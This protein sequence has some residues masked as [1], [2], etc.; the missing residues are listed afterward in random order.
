MKTTLAWLKSHLDTEASLDRIV[1]TLVMSGLEVDSIE[2]RAK[3][4]GAFT[5]ARVISAEP[6]PNADKLRVCL[7]D[8]GTEQ[9]RVVCGAPNARRGMLGVFAPP[10][11]VIPR[12]GMVLKQS[13]I[14]GAPSN[15]MLCSGYELGLSEDHEGI[16]ELPEGSPVGAKF[17]AVMGL[18]DPVLDIKVTPNR[19]DCLGV[20]GIARDLAATGLGRLKPLDAT[21]V[22]GR[23]PCPVAVHLAGPDDKACPL[24]IGRLIRGVKNGPS[25]RWL[26]DRLTAIGLRPISALVDLTNFLTFDV[27]RPLHV[28]DADKIAGDLVVRGARPGESLV[29]LNG[30]AYELDR[31]MTV[32]AD[33]REVLSLGGVIGGESTGCTG[34]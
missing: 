5:V 32:I 33:D 21:P 10:G 7:V 9:V 3:D 22:F 30:K 28:F 8:T 15:G 25:P 12:S 13:V 34:G 23:F 6:H 29:A 19:A 18:D 11:A 31:E 14:R 16:I 17:A 27:D 24:F 4:L 1:A 26:Q 2:D 20:R